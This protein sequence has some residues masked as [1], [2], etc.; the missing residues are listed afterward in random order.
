M[1]M[2]NTSVKYFLSRSLV[3]Q[4]KETLFRTLKE[5]KNLKNTV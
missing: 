4:S 2:L 3:R 1:M 5:K